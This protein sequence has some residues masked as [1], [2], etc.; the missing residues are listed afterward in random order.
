MKTSGGLDAELATKISDEYW[1]L[2]NLYKIKPK[3]GPPITFVFNSVQKYL[4]RNMHNRNVILKA[5]QMGFSTF[6]QIYFLDKALFNSGVQVGI[7]AQKQTAATDIFENKIKFA[8]DNLPAELRQVRVQQS[9]SKRELSFS[10]DSKITVDLSLRS[11]TYNYVHI[12]EYGEICANRPDKAR[13]IKTGA[14]NTVEASKYNII[15]IESTA[16]GKSGHFWTLCRNNWNKTGPLTLMD[17]KFLFFP[18]WKAPEYTLDQK[19]PIPDEMSEYFSMLKEKHDIRLSNAQKYW[20]VK[21]SEEQ[22]EDG[23]DDNDMKREMPSYKEEAFDRA[24]R[25]AIFHKQMDFL[26]KEG[27]IGDVPHTPGIPVE[28]FWDLGKGD[29]TAIWFMQRVNGENRFIDYYE[30][31]DEF[32]DHYFLELQTRARERK[33][34]YGRCYLPHD[35]GNETVIGC[36]AS[37]FRDAGFKPLVGTRV[38]DKEDAHRAAR[39]ALPTVRID[40]TKCK[41]GVDCLKNYK[42]KWNEQVGDFGGAVHDWASHGSDAFMEYAMNYRGSAVKEP[43]NY[44]NQKRYA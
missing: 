1:R 29:F 35:G 9:D 43:I 6:W 39:K 30:F 3:S 33:Y 17:Y 20:Y 11:G 25:G 21:K 41:R 16:M 12:S 5:R 32:L 31:N 23:E 8:Y 10:N 19:V 4:Y 15:A 44:R 37:M 14:L 36:A 2:N 38:Q 27:R 24:V 34:I 42:R 40:A 28:T 22:E 13:E 7:I 18:W 26:E